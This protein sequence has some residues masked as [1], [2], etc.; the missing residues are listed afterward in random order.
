M[1]MMMMS[2]IC[3]ASTTTM[4]ILIISKAMRSRHTSML[5]VAFRAKAIIGTE[6]KNH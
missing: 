2:P 6:K 3:R 5:M 1:M 4:M